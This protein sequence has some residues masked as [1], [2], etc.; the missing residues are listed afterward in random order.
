M[1]GRCDHFKQESFRVKM[2]ADKNE[3]TLPKISSYVSE[4]EQNMDLKDKI[5]LIDQ[6]LRQLYQFC[7]QEGY[8][9][10]QI[11]R[12]AQP[13]LA[14]EKTHKRMKC[15]KKLAYFALVVAFIAGVYLYSPAYNKVCIYAKLASIK[16]SIY[17]ILLCF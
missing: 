14:V 9:P 5:A 11:E 15:L 4:A 6:E 1:T 3:N 12:C 10:T 7:V 8:S 13:M 2:A 17:N 16:V